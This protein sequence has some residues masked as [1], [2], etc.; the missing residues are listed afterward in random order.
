[1]PNDNVFDQNTDTNNSTASTSPFDDKLKEIVND[2]GEPKYKDV[3]SAL[4]A[5][6]A[7]QA[8][9]KRLEDEAKARLAEELKLREDLAQ[10]EALE[11]VV[12]RLQAEKTTS[13]EQTPPNQAGLTQ[14]D[15]VK[16]LEQVL[17]K[18][19]LESRYAQN[20]QDVTNTLAAK[21]GDKTKEAVATKAAELGTTPEALGKLSRENPKLVLSL[22]GEKSII[23]TPTTS[24][25]S[26]QLKPVETDIQLKRP[27]KSILVGPAAT[28]KNRA[29]LMRQIKEKVYKQYDVTA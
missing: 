20:L 10:K 17:T 7:S 19:E 12:R 3:Q 16:T 26:T 4:E 18:K 15:I 25:T 23:T 11:D 2:Q 6:K 29:E 21:F 28:D 14:D 1:M 8:H 27:E 5:L 9:I 24:S 13:K 22:F